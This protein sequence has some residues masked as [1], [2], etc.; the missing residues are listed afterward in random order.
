MA[1][2]LPVGYRGSRRTGHNSTQEGPLLSVPCSGLNGARVEAVEVP[3]PPLGHPEAPGVVHE[4]EALL[5]TLIIGDV[6]YRLQQENTR[7][8]N[9]AAAKQHQTGR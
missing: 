1:G 7:Y 8:E 2:V 9:T 6:P 5:D 4:D 3:Q